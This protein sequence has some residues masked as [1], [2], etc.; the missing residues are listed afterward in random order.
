[1]RRRLLALPVAV[2]AVA[3]G[4][5]LAQTGSDPYQAPE[6]VVRDGQVLRLATAASCDRDRLVKVRFTPPSGAVF[7]WFEVSVRGR[8]R[9]RLTGVP[10]A[11]SATVKLA[12]GRSVVRVRGETLGGQRVAAKRVYRTCAPPPPPEDSPIQQ[13]GG[14]D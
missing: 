10:R 11:A 1:M 5:A 13:G 7:G 14:E 6:P 2:A 9:V 8:Q 12:R 3:G 4:T